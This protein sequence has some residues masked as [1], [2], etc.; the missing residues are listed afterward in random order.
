MKL[1]PS[2]HGMRLMR[3]SLQMMLAVGATN[4]YICMLSFMYKSHVAGKGYHAELGAHDY[5]AVMRAV[6]SKTS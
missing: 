4:R 3:P 2:S 1:M 5:K 6:V